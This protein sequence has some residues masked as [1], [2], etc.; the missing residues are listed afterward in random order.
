MD[1][2]LLVAQSLTYKCIHVN[3]YAYL[4]NFRLATHY[5]AEAESS[6][7]FKLRDIYEHC[8]ACFQAIDVLPPSKDLISKL[9]PSLF[10]T[11]K[12][13]VYSGRGPVYSVP[14]D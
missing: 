12:C 6:N 2:H 9:I 10:K 13:L 5:Q 4:V 14:R 7:P 11:E 1:A 8:E 3:D